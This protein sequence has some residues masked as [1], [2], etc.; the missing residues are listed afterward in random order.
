MQV[1][2]IKCERGGNMKASIKLE[3]SSGG[4][5]YQIVNIFRKDLKIRYNKKLT[6]KVR[7]YV[8]EKNALKSI[9]G[10]LSLYEHSLH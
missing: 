7:L 5:N 1:T 10:I 2:W 6:G 3:N 4:Q 9:S 8:S